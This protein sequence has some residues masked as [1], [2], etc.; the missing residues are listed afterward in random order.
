MK[1]DILIIDDN[2]RKAAAQAVTIIIEDIRKSRGKF[3]LT[4]AGESGAGKSE[5]AQSIAEKLEEYNLKTYVF[6][7]DDYFILPPKTNEN[8]RKEDIEWVGM[9]EVKLDLLDQNLLDAIEKNEPIT[10]PLVDFN[11]DKIGEE[12]VDLSDYDVLIAEGTYTTSLKNVDCRIFIDRNKMDTVES[13]KKRAR[14]AQDKF[15]DDI[16]TIEHEIIS[17]HK[18]L[19][20][21]IITKQFNAI[22]ND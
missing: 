4:V 3:S 21:V 1:G 15:L 8:K 2:H 12:T 22:I 7:Q 18:E 16:L 6:G 5:I 19:A 17:K 9:S 14:E 20:N 13:R 11:A 10:K